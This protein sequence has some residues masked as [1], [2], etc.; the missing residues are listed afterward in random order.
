[1]MNMINVIS[2][3][4]DKVGNSETVSIN[5]SKLQL[6]T[7]HDLT[8]N[9]DTNIMSSSARDNLLENFGGCAE[10]KR[11]ITVII[12]VNHVFLI[13]FVLNLI[14]GQVEMKMLIK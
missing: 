4:D 1:M 10:C 9:N 3:D 6:S 11:P 13:I 5:S 8:N 14:N 7:I 12:G 2:Y